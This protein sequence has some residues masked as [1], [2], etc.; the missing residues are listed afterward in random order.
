MKNS[1]KYYDDCAKILGFVSVISFSAQ[2]PALVCVCD[3]LTEFV[4]L[5]EHC[6]A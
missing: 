6:D 1:M 4:A 5:Q 2:P 3:V